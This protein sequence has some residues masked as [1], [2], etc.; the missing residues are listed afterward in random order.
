MSLITSGENGGMSIYSNSRNLTGICVQKD[1]NKLKMLWLL[2]IVLVF[3]DTKP[4]DVWKL[5]KVEKLMKGSDG[6]FVKISTKK[7]STISKRSIQHLHPLEINCLASGKEVQS[8]SSTSPEVVEEPQL[9]PCEKLLQRKG[10]KEGVKSWTKELY[11][12]HC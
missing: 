12:I 4:R 7:V 2:I 8:D 10:T 1:R 3:S 5:A 11:E 9:K 6:A